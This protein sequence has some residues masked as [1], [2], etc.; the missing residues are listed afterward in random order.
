MGNFEI[1]RLLLMFSSV[2]FAMH[3]N[4]IHYMKCPHCG[5]RHWQKKVLK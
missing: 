4:R 3:V 5:K 1:L 2:L